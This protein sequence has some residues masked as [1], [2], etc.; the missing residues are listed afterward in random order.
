MCSRLYRSPCALLLCAMVFAGRKCA[1]RPN[2]T[3]PLNCKVL[4]GA[5]C[6]IQ[7]LGVF[8][9]SCVLLAS[10]RLGTACAPLVSQVH[11]HSCLQDPCGV[12][13]TFFVVFCWTRTARL[14]RTAQNIALCA[15]QGISS[16]ADRWLG[17]NYVL[18]GLLSNLRSCLHKASS[19]EQH[20]PT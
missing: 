1:A 16:P 11:A 17:V 9:R 3:I 2:S 4:G 7:W 10:N 15:I 19:V 6:V 5:R 20:Y 14:N 18:Y 12:P 8:D 13:N